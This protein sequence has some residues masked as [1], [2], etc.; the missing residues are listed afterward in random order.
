MIDNQ[1]R[2]E[3][4]RANL[5]ESLVPQHLEIIDESAKHV[6]H[7]GAKGGGGHFRVQIVADCFEGKS[8]LQR[9]RLIYDSL[10]AMMQHD[11]HALS[12]DAKTP[13]ELA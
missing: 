6:G 11:I 12:I 1:Q 5:Q 4:I 10:A 3:K 2:V 8:L 7:E 9:H 13:A